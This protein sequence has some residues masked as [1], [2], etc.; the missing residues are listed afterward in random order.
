MAILLC[1]IILLYYIMQGLDLDRY[2]LT[3]SRKKTIQ[4]N[5]PLL[6]YYIVQ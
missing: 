5:T 2:K 3:N 1:Y 4:D 6:Y